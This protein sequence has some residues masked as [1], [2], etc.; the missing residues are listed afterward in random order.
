MPALWRRI[1]IFWQVLRSAGSSCSR[2]LMAFPLLR[3]RQEFEDSGTVIFSNR[4]APSGFFSTCADLIRRAVKPKY[5]QGPL[6]ETIDR[7]LF[8]TTTIGDLKHRVI[9]PTINLTKG[10][11]QIFKTPHNPSLAADKVKRL[12]DIALASS[13]APTYFP[14]AEVDDALYADGGLFAASP[15]YL[16]VH[17]AVQFLGQTDEDIHILSI[18]TTTARYS[19]AHANGIDLGILSWSLRNRL[20]RVTLAAQQQS[21]EFMMRHRFG[22]RYLR[23][24]A[25]QSSDQ[26]ARLALDVA[27]DDAKKTL[28]ALAKS[29]I[30]AYKKN[31]TL[32]A[33]MQHEAAAATFYNG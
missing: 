19:F 1:S 8:P 24:D 29:T 9:I 4:A 16:A 21:V 3:I 7:L 14:I 33:F 31:K 12:T 26:E 27:T 10:S 22:E 25:E 28:R 17:E 5:S 18:G 11:P 30:Q 23:L 32:N 2:L 6:R 13:S 20:I 15:D